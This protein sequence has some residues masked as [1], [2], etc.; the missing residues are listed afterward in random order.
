MTEWISA[1]LER[2]HHHHKGQNGSCVQADPLAVSL[3]G[4]VG[5]DVLEWGSFL[6]IGVS[7]YV[8]KCP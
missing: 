3:V 8:C 5:S 4:L 2:Y 7:V 6:Y 1:V